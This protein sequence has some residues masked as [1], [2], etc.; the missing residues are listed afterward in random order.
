[1]ASWLVA[2]I[3][4]SSGP[5]S[6]PDREHGFFGQVTL[7][8]RCLSPPRSI[9]GY[10]R[11]VGGNLTNCGEVPCDWPTSCPCRGSRNART[12]FMLRKPGETP[13]SMSQS[14]LKRP[15]H[16][17]LKL[18]NLRWCV[19]GAK[20]VG[21]HVLVVANS[22]PTCLSA[23]FCAVHTRQLEFASTS[24]ATLVCRVKAA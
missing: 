12:R 23:V 13:E 9:N 17:K 16:G 24:L 21:K 19:N 4:R 7:L 3:P 10:R 6:S 22:L 8:S 11:I 1:M 5:G 2:L 14:A 20:T 15:S 18:A